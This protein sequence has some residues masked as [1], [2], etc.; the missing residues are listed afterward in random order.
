MSEKKVINNNEYLKL[1]GSPDEIIRIINDVKDRMESIKAFDVVIGWGYDGDEIHY[2]RLETDEEF[3][4]RIE[5]E[6]RKTQNRI[7]QLKK[8][9]LGY[10]VKVDD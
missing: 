6:D 2:K 1:Y 10:G 4:A 3:N 9:L 5:K 8:E 7:E